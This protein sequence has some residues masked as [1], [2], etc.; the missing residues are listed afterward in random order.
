MSPNAFVQWSYE[1]S[2][3]YGYNGES[4]EPVFTWTYSIFEKIAREPITPSM[5]DFMA[6]YVEDNITKESLY[7]IQWGEY[8]PGELEEQAVN[9]YYDRPILDRISIHD[10]TLANLRAER[11]TAEEKKHAAMDWIMDDEDTEMTPE[12]PIYMELCQFVRS[13]VHKNNDLQMDLERRI[14]EEELWRGGHEEGM[15]DDENLYDPMEE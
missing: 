11:N 3:L 9:A 4:E 1:K 14:H 15:S 6:E 5:Y 7:E 8:G 13:L 2:L 12:N 10:R